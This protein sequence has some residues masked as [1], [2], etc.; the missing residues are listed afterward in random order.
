MN[1]KRPLI[2]VDWI[3][4]T[5]Y[6]RWV[7]EADTKEQTPLR[8]RSVGWRM[9]SSHGCVTLVGMRGLENL[10]CSNMQII[11]RGCITSIRRVE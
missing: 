11:P 9:S 7:F 10:N 4:I 2:V 6:Q 1:T 5:S 8:M 3:D